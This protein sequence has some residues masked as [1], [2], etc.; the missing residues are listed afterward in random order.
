VSNVQG[1]IARIY[2]VPKGECATGIEL[3]QEANGTVTVR[4]G[5]NDAP[6]CESAT[7]SKPC[8]PEPADTN[9]QL[10]R[11]VWN[12]RG[13]SY[14]RECLVRLTWGAS[15]Y[16]RPVSYLKVTYKFSEM[17]YQSS[18][19]TLGIN[20]TSALLRAR[21]LELTMYVRTEPSF[22]RV[23]VLRW[24]ANIT[25]SNEHLEVVELQKA[26]EFASRELK[27][28]DKRNTLSR[29][30]EFAA[31]NSA[32]AHYEP[33]GGP[34]RV[35]CTNTVSDVSSGRKQVTACNYTSR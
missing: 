10:Q 5:G 3:F 4:V 20:A 28:R 9:L 2:A 8:S 33:N 6:R 17:P 34:V 21:T 25:A 12:T 27:E 16:G 24:G 30:R 26:V 7:W 35:R 29:L 19:V 32:S 11:G 14:E 22:P 13:G 18:K 23:A 1:P 15:D 31:I